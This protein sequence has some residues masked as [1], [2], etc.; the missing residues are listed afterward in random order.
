MVA[1][2]VALLPHICCGNYAIGNLL[3][4]ELV[5]LTEAKGALLWNAVGRIMRGDVLTLIGK[6]PDAVQMISTG[7]RRRESQRSDVVYTV[8]RVIVGF[9]ICGARQIR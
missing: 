2:V 8:V 1:L 7:D 6:Y 3:A 5:A 9:G 4:D